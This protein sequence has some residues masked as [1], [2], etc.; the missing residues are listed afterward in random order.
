M[1]VGEKTAGTGSDILH[2][3]GQGN[4]VRAEMTA[5]VEEEKIGD[6]NQ[7]CRDA[8]NCT[9]NAGDVEK[10]SLMTPKAGAMAAPA[11]TVRSDIDRIVSVSFLFT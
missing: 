1:P 5:D 6:D 10:C 3:S 9:S 7:Q 8:H 2:Q 4:R 11:I